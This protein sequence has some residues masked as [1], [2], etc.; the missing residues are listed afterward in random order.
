MCFG[1]SEDD[2]TIIGSL[3]MGTATMPTTQGSEPPTLKAAVWPFVVVIVIQM[4]FAAGSVST[5]TAIRSWILL[6]D[7]WSRSEQEATSDLT[8]YA[9]TGDERA[10]EDY[11]KAMKLP[12]T[13]LGINSDLTKDDPD[14][15]RSRSALIKAGNFL[16]DSTTMSLSLQYL[17]SIDYMRQG[18]SLAHKASNLT[19]TL[20]LLAE[21]LHDVL[22]RSDSRA[23]AALLPEIAALDTDAHSII[24]HAFLIFSDFARAVERILMCVNLGL[25]CGLASL[26]IWR[27]RR[28]LKQRRSIEGVLSWQASHD[29]LTGMANRRAFE[30]RLEAAASNEQRSPLALMF[31]DLDQFKIVNDTCGH[32]AGDELLR[33]ICV[34]LQKEL[35]QSDLL[36]RL[37]G[38]EFSIFLADC[39]LTRA[40]GLA[41]TLRTVV[42]D[43]DF[44]WNERVFRVTASIGLVHVDGDHILAE[45]LMRAADMACFMAKEKGRNRVHIHRSEDQDLVR[46][47]GEMNWVQRIH[48]ALD[49]NRFCLYAQDIVSLGSLREEGLHIELLIR[50]R[51]E[52]GALVP[53]GSFLP[54]AER[55]G[56]MGLIDRW[57]VGTAFRILADR[58]VDTAAEPMA[59]CAINLSGATI[60]DDAFLEFLEQQFMMTGI[61][62]SMICFEITE[63]SAIRNLAAAR[64]F[65]DD[66]RALGCRFSL[67]DFGSGMSSFAYLKH[68]PVDFLKIDGS[69]V[70][71]LLSDKVDRSM[72]EAINQIGHVMGKYIIAEFVETEALMETLGQMGVDYGQGYGIAMPKPFGRNYRSA[73]ADRRAPALQACA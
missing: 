59:C 71:N 70:K 29:P 5:L 9:R 55:F 72:V 34:P 40:I 28:F 44:V 35:G 42:Q 67:D 54:A 1:Q 10:F 21:H 68:L 4:L 53:P 46:H 57:V 73:E 60:G 8:L 50:L 32:G 41:E 11:N 26:T 20:D 17:R 6:V 65:V 39:P 48:Q 49:E 47:A 62:P 37:G 27:V 14:P 15:Q 38:D 22:I 3:T 12:R 16:D 56:L 58:M 7:N 69:F 19:M 25:A 24:D 36:A 61:S 31:I 13:C 52:T 63:T 30:D 23:A 51:D 33:R 2:G 18:M 45:E 66:L 43:F 64:A